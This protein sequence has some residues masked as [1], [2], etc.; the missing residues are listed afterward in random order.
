ME[1]LFPVVL[2]FFG[3]NLRPVNNKDEQ[4]KRGGSLWGFKGWLGGTFVINAADRFAWESCFSLLLY[5]MPSGSVVRT[6]LAS[7]IPV[8]NAPSA[9]E[10][11]Y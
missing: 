8:N 9:R 11:S 10:L 5:S 3:E 7:M 1:S 4:C 6:F 2:Q